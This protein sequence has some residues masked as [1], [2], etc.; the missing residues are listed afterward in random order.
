MD[1]YGKS[2]RK[3]PLLMERSIY[4]GQ[5]NS[6]QNHNGKEMDDME[7]IKEITFPPEAEELAI[8]LA[9]FDIMKQLAAEGRIT[10]GELKYLADKCKIPVE[11]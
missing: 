3:I 5:S 11:K 4:E 9:A 2:I 1:K 10:A 8:K 7:E 6:A